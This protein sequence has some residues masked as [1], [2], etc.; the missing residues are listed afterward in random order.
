MK[1][2][3]AL[4]R[5]HCSIPDELVARESLPSAQEGTHAKPDAAFAQQEAA[6]SAVKAVTQ[7]ASKTGAPA[8]HQ[9]SGLSG[10]GLG[11]KLPS[12]TAKAKGTA[13]A[14]A[15]VV[16]DT[17]SQGAGEQRPCSQQA[18]GSGPGARASDTAVKLPANIQQLADELLKMVQEAKL[19]D[20]SPDS[21]AADDSVDMGQLQSLTDLLLQDMSG[22]GGMD[23]QALAQQL[24]EQAQADQG[25]SSS[26]PRPN[27]QEAGGALQDDMQAEAVK[28][29]ALRGLMQQTKKTVEEQAKL[30][31][32]GTAAT[33]AGASGSGA[34]SGGAGGRRAGRGAGAAGAAAGGAGFPFAD[35]LGS[36]GGAGG[37]LGGLG[38]AAGG[39]ESSFMV[40]FIMQNLLSKD[41][42]YGPLKEIRDK[43]PPWLAEQAASGS[44]PDHELQRYRLQ[45]EAIEQVCCHYE[46]APKD[47]KRLLEL[48]QQMQQ[49]GDPPK[50]I[51]DEISS[52]TQAST[53]EPGADDEVPGKQRP[54]TLASM[55]LSGWLKKKSQSKS[56]LAKK[57]QKRWFELTDETLAYAKDPKELKEANIVVFSLLECQWVK[58]IDEIKLE[59]RFPERVLRVAAESPGQ[60]DKWLHAMERNQ[61]I[62]A[63]TIEADS[64]EGES[65][66]VKAAPAKPAVQK[67]APLLRQ[68]SPPKSQSLQL[69]ER[70]PSPRS[71]LANPR[72]GNMMMST[73]TKAQPSEDDPEQEVQPFHSSGSE[74][75]SQALPCNT[76]RYDS[77]VRTRS[78]EP[79]RSSDRAARL[80]IP[81]QHPPPAP[82][83]PALTAA[84][85][86]AT[87]TANSPSPAYDSPRFKPLT[88]KVQDEYSP[89]L[90][91]VNSANSCSLVE[92]AASEA[93]VRVERAHSPASSSARGT[94]ARRPPLPPVPAQDVLTLDQPASHTNG[95]GHGSRPGS[96]ASSRFSAERHK[97]LPS[98]AQEERLELSPAP[99]PAPVPSTVSRPGAG[100]SR[101]LPRPQPPAADQVVLLSPEAAGAARIRSA[102]PRAGASST[103]TQGL[104]GAA[105][106]RVMQQPP[107]SQPSH[108]QAGVSEENWVEEDWDADSSD[109][110]AHSTPAASSRSI[111]NTPRTAGSAKTSGLVYKAS[112]AQPQQMAHRDADVDSAMGSTVS[113][114]RPVAPTPQQPQAVHSRVEQQPDRLAAA[115]SGQPLMRSSWDS[116][117]DEGA[118]VQRQHH[119]PV[120][121]SP[122][123]ALQQP[124]KGPNQVKVQ[125]RLED[126]DEMQD[127]RQVAG[128][129]QVRMHKNQMFAAQPDSGVTADA[130]FVEENWDSD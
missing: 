30:G 121:P 49:H 38:G 70:P 15:P 72:M 73:P 88:A 35:L 69:P 90:R 48:V 5:S 86:A 47:F 124:R 36:L 25:P 23:L 43:Y 80:N 106:S 6:A 81:L 1:N 54:D 66:V 94:G 57:Y 93:A 109:G 8:K 33:G 76:E 95:V 85:A 77:P 91:S 116:D 28:S 60:A 39:E 32:M 4:K 105:T 45:L 89:T 59:M 50:A 7:P 130:A 44:L 111:S 96:A 2:H 11:P 29:S 14:V 42:L 9:P 71:L 120:Q 55:I 115:A 129:G 79:G 122:P 74:R 92:D 83:A 127:L 53:T 112:T 78:A 126:S 113:R 65:P 13:A 68:I 56:L 104:S 87:V 64:D 67:A 12:R 20:D 41:V 128:S 108:S 125:G 82:N 27:S 18:V 110:E 100:L 84:A 63:F 40:D 26:S 3:A 19:G 22:P 117:D 34:R 52:S 62:T 99:Q 107:A 118:G 98:A 51:V 17:S 101:S 58:R 114:T 97:L 103:S 16:K 123:A 119:P 21:P 10:A 46:T 37:L 75:D 31:R 102:G 61:I 24:R